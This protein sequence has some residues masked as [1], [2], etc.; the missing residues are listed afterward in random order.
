M[1]ASRL[2]RVGVAASR[3]PSS[4]ARILNVSFVHQRVVMTVSVLCLL[5]LSMLPVRSQKAALSPK[6]AVLKGNVYSNSYFGFSYR[7][8]SHLRVDTDSFEQALEGRHGVAQTHTYVL[9]SARQQALLPLVKENVVIMADEAAPY[10]GF[11]DG[12]AYLQ[13]VTRWQ[14]KEGFEVLRES[15]EYMFGGKK[16]FRSDYKKSGLLFPVYLSAVFTVWH[17]YAVG[18]IFTAGSKER[19]EEAVS[20]LTTLEFSEP[21]AN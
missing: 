2:S 8:P 1:L 13:K 17:G 20:S 14:K 11:E 21:Q 15:A 6:S 19:M 7:V 9:L 10:G 12:N 18:F 5:L 16:F 4:L 3:L